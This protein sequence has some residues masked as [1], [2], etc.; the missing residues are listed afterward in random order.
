MRPQINPVTANVG[1]RP[2]CYLCGFLD[3]DPDGE[4]DAVECRP[5]GVNGAWICFT[6]MTSTPENQAEAKR[7]FSSQLEGSGPVAIIG[8]NT[9]PRPLKKGTQ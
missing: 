6:C 9:G 1:E 8:E 4:G 7:Q 3:G 2:K 5:Y